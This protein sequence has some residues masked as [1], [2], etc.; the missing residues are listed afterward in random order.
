MKRVMN[1]TDDWKHGTLLP[2]YYWVRD[3]DGKVRIS[4]LTRWVSS[5]NE[6][7]ELQFEGEEYIEEVLLSCDYDKIDYMKETI[8]FL[9]RRILEVKEENKQLKQLLEKCRQYVDKYFEE[10]TIAENYDKLRWK[11]QSGGKH[12][13]KNNDVCSYFCYTIIDLYMEGLDA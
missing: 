5:R 2:G 11:K 3:K 9:K 10:Q 7:L 13:G 12:T 6:F 4:R 1:L 8:S